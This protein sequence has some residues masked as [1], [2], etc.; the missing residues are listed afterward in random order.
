MV[1][2]RKRRVR[3]D[4]GGMPVGDPHVQDAAIGAPREPQR[5][6]GAGAS[7]LHRVRDKL[8]DQQDGIVRF[9]IRDPPRAKRVA[10]E[11]PCPGY[12]RRLRVEER[13]RLVT[14]GSSNSC[15]QS[16]Q[17]IAFGDHYRPLS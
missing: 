2:A 16:D 14:Q 5:E 8:T 13:A 7:V 4:T 10:G 3:D 6:A 1:V 15:A 17:F 12:R 11:L 9:G